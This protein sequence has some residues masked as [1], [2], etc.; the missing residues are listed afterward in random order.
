LVILFNSFVIAGLFEEMTKY[1][2]LF[3]I[4]NRKEFINIEG[5]VFYSISGSL[6]FFFFFINLKK[7]KKIFKKK[8]GKKNK[9]K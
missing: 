4:R 3:R 9:I 6:G 7:V 8:K 2:L 1:F 5:S